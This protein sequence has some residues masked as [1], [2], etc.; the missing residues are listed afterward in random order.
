MLMH[1]YVIIIINL[2]SKYLY[3]CWYTK[4]VCKNASMG[5]DLDMELFNHYNIVMWVDQHLY[6]KYVLKDVV[7]IVMSI[8]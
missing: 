7:G 6:A 1:V 5:A 3:L 4:L 2:Q 8:P